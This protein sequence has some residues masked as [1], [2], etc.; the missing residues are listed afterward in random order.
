MIAHGH[1]IHTLAASRGI[2]PAG[3][4]SHCAL[5]GYDSPYAAAK[6]V[7][8]I[9]A[10]DI[11]DVL[12]AAADTIC[13]ACD[14]VIG[15]KPGRNPVPL[16][17]RSFILEPAGEIRLLQQ[18]DWWAVL[19]APRVCIASWAVS[20]KK[21]HYLHADWSTETHWRIGTDDGAAEWEHDPALLDMVNLLRQHGAPKAAILS[22][23]YP[24]ALL[25]RIGQIIEQAERH[26]ASYRGQLSLDM[27]V[28]ACPTYDRADQLKEAAESM[29]TEN[30][31]KAR[32]LLAAIAWGSEMRANDGKIFW[33]GYYLARIRRHARLPV[34]HMVSRLFADCAVGAGFASDIAETVAGMSCEDE[35]GI[36]EVCR[37]R[38]DLLHALAFGQMKTYRAGGQNQEALI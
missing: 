16:R 21:H 2:A 5:C 14:Y 17:M 25:E 26:I 12:R 28:H 18:A 22:G 23:A 36:S 8:D 19:Q 29:L 15:G 11:L 27:V 32:D 34:G 4:G 33:N 10:P 13:A 37:E 24:P 7:K 35:T 38:P 9:T 30:E 1:P 31:K 3:D 6:R 20:G